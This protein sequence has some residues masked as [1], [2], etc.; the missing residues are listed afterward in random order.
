MRVRQFGIMSF[1]LFLFGGNVLA[2]QRSEHAA[3]PGD[4]IVRVRSGYSNGWCP[5]GYCETETTVEPGLVITINR[6]L[7]DKK[8]YP[9]IKVQHRITKEAWNQL[10]SAVDAKIRTAFA[11]S[12]GCPGCADQPME[13]LEVQFAN[14]TKKSVIFSSGNAPPGLAKLLR[15]IKTIEAEAEAEP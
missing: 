8:K 2:Q 9:N 13:W 5:S 10:Q 11:D 3:S 1:L 14:G 4:H 15:T 7:S 12:V 6:A